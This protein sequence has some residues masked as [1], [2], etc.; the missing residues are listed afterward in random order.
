M[1]LQNVD[2]TLRQG[3]WNQGIYEVSTVPKEHLGT[4]RI[5]S[6][7]EKYRYASFN[8]TIPGGNLC[9]QVPDGD[10]N[11]VAQAAPTV[12]IAAKTFTFTPGGAVTYG[13]NEL[14]GGSVM[15]TEG[16]GLGQ[17]RRIAG[18][19]AESAGTVLPII[20]EEGFAVA[21]STADTK[22]SVYPSEY[23][24]VIK[25]A[26]ITNPIVGIAVGTVAALNWGWLQT[27]GLCCCLVTGTPALGAYV[28]ANATDGSVGIADDDVAVGSQ[29]VGVIKNTAGATGKYYPVWLLIE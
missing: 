22:M 25:A 1:A 2:L 7:G 12:A 21:T 6:T 24:K 29:I 27:A 5:S 9:E 28:I 3:A 8:A 13:D 17:I 4:L 11:M 23:R 14:Q 15:T 20:L 26:T 16:T 10:A 19:V 18:N